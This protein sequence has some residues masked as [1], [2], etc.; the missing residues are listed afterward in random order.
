MPTRAAAPR[1]TVVVGSAPSFQLSNQAK[2]TVAPG[3]ALEDRVTYTQAQQICGLK[4]GYLRQRVQR[5]ELTRMGRAPNHTWLSRTEVEDLAMR[6]HRRNQQ[7][8]YWVT[9]TEAAAIL[10]VNRTTTYLLRDQGRLPA[11]Q[12]ADGVWLAR[13]ADVHGLQADNTIR[14]R[15]H[16]PAP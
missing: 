16:D 4:A 10:H 9:M 5:G 1:Q 13:R 15:Q 8:G 2:E 7:T 12:S 3:I 11:R 14:G 6:V